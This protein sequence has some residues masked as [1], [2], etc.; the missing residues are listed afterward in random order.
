LIAPLVVISSMAP[1][2]PG[3]EGILRDNPKQVAL[4]KDLCSDEL[5]QQHIFDGYRKAVDAAGDPDASLSSSSSPSSLNNKVR[6]LAKQLS[7]L[8]STYPGGL[9][10]YID[11][12][13]KLLQDSKAGV[14]PLEGWTPSIPEGEKVDLESVK[15]RN[16]EKK[17]IPLLGKVGFVLVAGGLGE[18]LGYNGEISYSIGRLGR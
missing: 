15:Y 12:A 16:T 5:G 14:N 2:P 7:K 9:R 18:R 11:K 13:K 6:S 4:L 8:N 10:S 17:G 3:V 1:L